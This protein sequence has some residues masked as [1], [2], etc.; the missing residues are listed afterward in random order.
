MSLIEI[1]WSP[2]RKQLRQFGFLCLLVL[3]LL[4]WLWSAN[5][6]SIIILLGIGSLIAFLAN[7]Q[8]RWVQ[9]L[10]VG[11]VLVTAPIGMVVGELAMLLIYVGVFLPI[12]LLFRLAHR[13][14]LQLR[15]DR[16]AETYWQTKREPKDI[17]S[18]YRRY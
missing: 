7:V 15:M 16:E 18:Y 11:L 9:P 14:A 4:G 13:D 17:A 12:S 5:A 1:N 3:P 6:T 10:F 8:P 2:S